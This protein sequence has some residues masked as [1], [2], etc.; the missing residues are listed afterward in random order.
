M[1]SRTVVLPL[2][3]K[4]LPHE[5]TER[6]DAY[7][8]DLEQFLGFALDNYPFWECDEDVRLSRYEWFL[9][10]QDDGN[11]HEIVVAEEG[12]YEWHDTL[13]VMDQCMAFLK[14]QIDYFLRYEGHLPPRW[15]KLHLD[16]VIG[17][18]IYMTIQPHEFGAANADAHLPY[19]HHA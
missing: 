11:G 12:W 2:T 10:Q 1:K 19:Q 7:G 14:T 4:E 3:L 5:F 9:R 17:Q 6:M 16:R 15:P 8:V 13:K 18:D